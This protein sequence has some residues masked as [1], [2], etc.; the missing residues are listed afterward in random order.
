MT[1]RPG[2]IHPLQ[3]PVRPAPEPA[4]EVDRHHDERVAAGRRDDAGPAIALILQQT[5]GDALARPG[6]EARKCRL[7]GICRRDHRRR[8]P[9]SPPAIADAPGR[10]RAS[11]SPSRR[12]VGFEIDDEAL[13]RHRRQHVTER[14]HH[15]HARAAER[16]RLAAIGGVAIAD[17]EPLEI[18]HVVAARLAAALGAAIE[19]PV[20]EH[21]E[22]AV[23]G[24]VHVELDHIGPCCEGGLHRRQCVLDLRDDRLANARRRAGVVGQARAVEVLVRAAM[25]DQ[26]TGAVR[27]LRQP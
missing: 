15:P 11:I 9:R 1:S 7:G 13:V 17:V 25:C 6:R 12:V 2:C 10:T 3:E 5:I 4:R 27:H 16:K 8:R 19:R 24:G 26:V 18:R 21:R 22:L 23:S 20:V 14:R